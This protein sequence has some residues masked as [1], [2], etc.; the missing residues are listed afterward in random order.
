MPMSIS[1]LGISSVAIVPILVDLVSSGEMIGLKVN[2]G[3]AVIISCVGA[4]MIVN[5]IVYRWV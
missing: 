1:G 3:D 4:G 5:S 2:S